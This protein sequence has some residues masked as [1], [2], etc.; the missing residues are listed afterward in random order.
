[1]KATSVTNA[2]WFALDGNFPAIFASLEETTVGSEDDFL[3]NLTNTVARERRTVKVVD[4][5]AVAV[6][7]GIDPATLIG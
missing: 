3:K 7:E 2:K 5:K 1:M 6:I 4:K